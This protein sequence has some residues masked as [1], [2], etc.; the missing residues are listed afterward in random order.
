MDDVIIVVWEA[1]NILFHTMALSVNIPSDELGPGDAKFIYI[2]PIENVV[3]EM[4]EIFSRPLCI[5]AT[6]ISISGNTT[7]Y[8]SPYDT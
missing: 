1:S 2:N 7:C 4:L 8:D 3:C 6:H 5:K